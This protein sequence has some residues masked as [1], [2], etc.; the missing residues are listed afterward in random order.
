VVCGLDELELSCGFDACSEVEGLRLL[1]FEPL[2]GFESCS[3]VEALRL[4]LLE[5]FCDLDDSESPCDLDAWDE[6]VLV[7]ALALDCGRVVWLD[8]VTVFDEEAAELPLPL[9]DRAGS[10]DTGAAL[11]GFSG[12]A[13]AVCC[14]AAGA[15]AGAVVEALTAAAD[16][17]AAGAVAVAGD[18]DAGADTDAV[19]PGAAG[20][21]TS[22]TE[23]IGIG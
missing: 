2:R 14:S 15:V 5:L 19:V 20:A 21:G 17:T 22:G 18:P 3:E 10:V 12:E 6:P 8:D 9:C 4:L 13:G 1:V 7:L 16:G 11:P 23:P